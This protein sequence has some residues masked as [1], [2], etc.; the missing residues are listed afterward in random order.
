[1]PDNELQMMKK[2]SI[3]LVRDK[4]TWDKL[5]KG[6]IEKLHKVIPQG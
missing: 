4:F 1:M 2:R 3:E 6:L 5:I